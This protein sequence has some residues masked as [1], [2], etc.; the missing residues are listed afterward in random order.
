MIYKLTDLL[1]KIS[2]EITMTGTVSTVKF[3]VPNVTPALAT[4]NG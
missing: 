3:N 2:L 1:Q 4:W